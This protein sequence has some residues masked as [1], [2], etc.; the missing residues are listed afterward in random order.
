MESYFKLGGF[1]SKQKF[2]MTY[3]NILL[4]TSESKAK[5]KQE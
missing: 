4:D 2:V 1:K 3:I 5:E